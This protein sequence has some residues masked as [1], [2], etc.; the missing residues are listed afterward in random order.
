[1]QTVQ[2]KAFAEPSAANQLALTTGFIVSLA[3]TA[4]PAMA[5]QVAAVVEMRGE[6]NFQPSSLTIQAGDTVEWRNVSGLPHTV[7]A[8]P[9]M[10]ATMSRCPKAPKPSVQASSRP[11]KVQPYLRRGVRV[12]LFLHPA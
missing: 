8:D 7:T 9:E 3:L 6:R 11:A 5:Q 1:M 10:A 4:L 2:E 12:S